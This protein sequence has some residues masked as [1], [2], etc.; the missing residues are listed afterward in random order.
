LASS[1]KF[2]LRIAE[3]GVMGIQFLIPIPDTAKM[4]FVEFYVSGFFYN[5]KSFLINF[6]TKDKKLLIAFSII[7]HLN[8]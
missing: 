6:L 4:A 1:T 5:L 8:F 2:A 3:S 7:P